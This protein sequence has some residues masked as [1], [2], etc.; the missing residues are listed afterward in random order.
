MCREMGCGRKGTGWKDDR[1]RELVTGVTDRDHLDGALPRAD[2]DRLPSCQY[3]CLEAMAS[4]VVLVAAR[5][6]A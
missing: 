3:E 1:R 6:V 5:A 2:D 4:E